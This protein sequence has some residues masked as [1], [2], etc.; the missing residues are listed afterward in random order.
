[1]A[2]EKGTGSLQLEKSGRWTLRV[3]IDG[4]RFSRSTRTKDRQKAE[5][6]LNRFLA[7]FGLGDRILPLA[8]VWREY[9]K[10]PNR[11]DQSV[12]TMQAKRKIW[13]Q[14]A[15]WMECNHVEISELKHLSADVVAE[16][17]RCVKA[18][19]SAGTYNNR[20]CVLREICRTVAEAG[21]ITD[22]PW[23]SVRLLPDDYHSRREFSPEE[24]RRIVA[25]AHR[26]GHHWKML[27]L[28]AMYTGLRLGDCCCLSWSSVNFERG[29]IQVIPRK[30]RKHSHG[31]P[32]TIPIH[33]SL[34]TGLSSLRKKNT[35]DSPYVL[36]DLASWYNEKSW[37]I[38]HGLSK[39]FKDAGIVT[40][41][42]LQGRKRATPDA[43]F[44]SLRHTFVSF[45]ANAGV[46]MPVVQSI[47]GHTSTAMTRHY[48]HENEAALRRAVESIPSLEQL[49]RQSVKAIHQPE[50]AH[51]K[52]SFAIESRLMALADL[53]QR[54]VITEAE[55]VAARQR[56]LSE[57]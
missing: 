49:K 12:A 33:P 53:R 52:T 17:L 35:G 5:A 28:I 21:G 29:I 56:V 41:V 45:A 30:T 2:R 20:V 6:Y 27:F 44:H 37:H 48:Y 38:E 19:H 47:V 34:F 36:P 16:Y 46:P 22:D 42:H 9:E 54:N 1:M 14:F 8:D 3:S 24:L 40:S 13:M 51:V 15:G 25:A 55:Y 18:N 10:S 57:I 31:K 23:A 32:V 39:M 50:E 26:L 11:R 4:K 43:T 7:P